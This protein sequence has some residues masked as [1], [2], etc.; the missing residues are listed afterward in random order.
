MTSV[1]SIR[2]VS[3]SRRRTRGQIV[4]SGRYFGCALGRGGMAARK[5]EGDGRTPIG[6]F[7]LVRVLY[8]AD[9]G[10]R[11]ATGLPVSVIRRH[12]GWCDAPSDRNYNRAVRLPYPASCE[13]MW[14]EDGLYDIV[15]VLEHNRR[16]RVRGAGSAIFM[17]LARP[18]YAPTEGCIALERRDLKLV[19]ARLGRGTRIAIG[20]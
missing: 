14:R 18:G 17:H 5:R 9:R 12:D 16:P 1:Q 4:F 8:R 15:V 13:Q 11:P 2:A 10:R 6:V 3:L 20:S 7:G 19:L